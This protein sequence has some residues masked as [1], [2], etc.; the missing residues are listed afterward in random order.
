M[1]VEK[2][3]FRE[4]NQM[5]RMLA[6]LAVLALAVAAC[7][8][9]DGTT[10]TSGPSGMTGD[11]TAGETVFVTC[12]A[13]H[14]PDATGI[15]GLGKDLTNSAFLA[16]RTDDEM[17]DFIKVGRRPDDPANETGVDMPPKG[18]N[19]AFSDQ[20]LYD[21]IAYLRTLPGN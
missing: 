7:G 17:V 18:G 8:G 13:C 2:R 11:A 12:S 5:R 1:K 15:E 16:D 20:D 10:A 4:R 3:P 21:V 19:P 9:G 14:G 6:I